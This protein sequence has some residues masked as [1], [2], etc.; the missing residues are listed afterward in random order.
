MKQ[1]GVPYLLLTSPSH[2]TYVT[3][4][5]GGDSWAL[6]APR[7]VFLLTDSRYTEQAQTESPY[8]RIHERSGSLAE[9][10]AL[11]I[12][13]SRSICGPLAVEK[14]ITVDI[15][16]HIKKHTKRRVRI[17]ADIIA[18]LRCQKDVI[19]IQA[20]KKAITVTKKALDRVKPLI[21]PGMTETVL[22]GH[23]DFEIRK[24]GATNAFETIVA[25][26]PHGS[27]PHHQPTQRRL[28]QRDTILIDFGAKVNGY[29]SD[30]TRCFVIGR[31]SPRYQKAYEAVRE[32]QA[33]ALHRVR[34]GVRIVDVD[35]AARRVIQTYDLP[36]Y[37]HGTGHGFG[38]DIHE[39][40]YLK[41]EV[42][43]V[44]QSNQVVTIEP[45]VY[46]PGLWG[47]RLEDD[48]LVTA[49]GCRILTRRQ[50]H[51]WKL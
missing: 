6:I 42:K 46:I 45:G 11:I 19:E 2:V 37:G 14:S 1:A 10:V 35:A 33:A 20:I 4:F 50:P 9:A 5:L 39:G 44:L 36:V 49:T 13:R 32:A 16:E 41:P 30:I 29:C 18:A 15:L 8:C 23:I 27:R 26:G 28:K 21:K 3:G 12:S 47:I 22:A 43:G 38:L 24:L 51:S 31:P 7:Q 17:L 40:P 34:A 25:F 48:V